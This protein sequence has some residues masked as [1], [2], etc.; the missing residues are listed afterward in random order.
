MKTRRWFGGDRV[1]SK[2]RVITTLILVLSAA[3]MAFLAAIAFIATSGQ[4]VAQTRA[5][6]A[7][8]PAT[9]QLSPEEL[10]FRKEW[11]E[12]IS[13]VPLPRKGCF[14]ASYPEKEW[15]EVPCGAP[16]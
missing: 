9:G 14:T 12:L 16:S 7:A 11:Q 8:S 13:K 10:R 6:P 2:L 5:A 3:A 1:F 4:A 15:K